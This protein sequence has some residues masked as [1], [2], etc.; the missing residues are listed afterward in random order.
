MNNFLKNKIANNICGIVLIVGLICFKTQ[1]YATENEKDIFKYDNSIQNMELIISDR[2]S[3]GLYSSYV[4]ESA[5]I[6]L[7]SENDTPNQISYKGKYG[8]I[9]W[10]IDKYGCLYVTGEGEFK[11]H[12]SDDGTFY[13]AP[14]SDYSGDIKTAIINTKNTT[15]IS[16]M[17]YQ[18][19]N[20]KRVQF[21]NTD[22]MYLENMQGTFAECYS[23]QSIVWG[24]VDTSNVKDMNALFANCL[25][26]EEVDL[27]LFNT[28]QLVNASYMFFGC[29]NLRNINF[30]SM[31]STKNV[32]YMGAMFAYCN[33][34][35]DLNISCF[36]CSS[37]S[38]NGT[39][40]MLYRCN[41]LS[42]IY[43]PLKIGNAEI[44]LYTSDSI[45]NIFGWKSLADKKYVQKISSAQN[46]VTIYEKRCIYD[47]W[48]MFTNS[49]QYFE[50]SYGDV[51][52]ISTKDLSVL[53]SNMSDA[54]K[55]LLLGR[56]TNVL[57]NP[58]IEFDASKSDRPWSGSC[59]GMATWVSLQNNNWVKYNGELAGTRFSDDVM[60]SINFY[61]IQQWL[62]LATDNT[63]VFNTKT[64]QERV[65]AITEAL[66]SGYIPIISYE[67]GKDAHA[68]CGIALR[69]I[70]PGEKTDTGFDVSGYEYC[71]IVYDPNESS[72]SAYS[73]CNI[74][75]NSDGTFCIPNGNI[76]NSNNKTDVKIK[77]VV[78]DENIINQID[79]HSGVKSEKRKRNEN[80][81]VFRVSIGKEYD[82]AWEGG[83]VHIN[84]NGS[85]SGLDSSS[86]SIIRDEDGID[87]KSALVVMPKVA[88]YRI[89]CKEGFEIYSIFDDY[90]AYADT[91]A[92][93]EIEVNDEGYIKILS[94]EVCE[95]TICNGLN[96]E[97]SLS[98]WPFIYLSSFEGTQLSLDL[99]EK[100][101]EVQGD[102]LIGTTI[103]V[104]K[105][106][107]YYCTTINSSSSI[108]RENPNMSDFQIVSNS[109]TEQ[110]D[111]SI[112]Q[113]KYSIS[114]NKIEC[115]DDG[116]NALI[117]IENNSDEIIDNWK[118][119]M[120]YD[121]IINSIW[122]AKQISLID[123]KYIINN[124]GW[125]QDI[126]PG[127]VVEIGM[128]VQGDPSIDPNN[129]SLEKGSLSISGADFTINTELYDCWNNGCNGNIFLT[130]LG[131]NEITD[132]VL[133]FEYN[134]D[135]TNIWN[136]ELL[137]NEEHH[138]VIKNAG[139]NSNIEP[140]QSISIGFN[141][142]GCS[143]K[144]T[145]FVLFTY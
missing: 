117:R 93:G 48:D 65:R 11:P 72:I 145:G 120:E 69:D 98:R 104:S 90:V 74:Y 97:T 122:N 126:M 58:N 87:G 89:A 8:N 85:V 135:I 15:D 66:N 40:Y 86:V 100:L 80:N 81:T 43:S 103:E 96:E 16:Q 124:V 13:Y 129:I 3:E 45:K 76:T 107:E 118:L 53:F 75:Y 115:W 112:T 67:Y 105:G 41:K 51:Y 95:K 52:Y 9:N 116:Y 114:F 141:S 134:A 78:Y 32:K 84:S 61:H 46:G 108:V 63:I 132:W 19:V 23:L 6:M 62:P 21:I 27:S 2:D 102:N 92:G 133:E 137:S 31:F 20:L 44:D 119:S 25:L 143:D 28:E 71:A 38:L 128:S 130:N 142:I 12:N 36:D 4:S 17:F 49:E 24:K 136:A 139:Y 35:K 70:E 68:V 54:E 39:G 88:Q 106:E 50:Q 82:I 111:N 7:L 94:K 59:Y 110:E 64:K 121:G 109:E 60:S 47:Y 123:N 144:P 56:D 91:T 113:S 83:N 140:G 34:L 101:I 79:Y 30:G 5:Q 73:D 42:K 55:T 10:E 99:R 77:R 37:L 1:A 14:W 57:Y 22:Y 131:D 125:N 26:L 127:Q 29:E 33:M 138:Y 18:C